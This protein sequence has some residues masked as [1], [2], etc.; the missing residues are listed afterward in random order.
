M[1]PQSHK[2]PDFGNFETLTS[3]S[4]DKMTFGCWSRGQAQSILK[5][6]RWWLSPSPGRGE[7]YE[8]MFARDSSVH[9][10]CSNSTLTNLLFGLCK[11]IWIIDP[12]I[13]RP[14][15]IPE[16]QHTPL[17]PKCCELM[18]MPQLL[19]FLLSS[20]F[21]SQLSPSRNSTS[22]SSSSTIFSFCCACLSLVRVLA[23]L[24]LQHL[25]LLKLLSFS[26][27]SIQECIVHHKVGTPL[28]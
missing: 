2:S 6:G 16:F 10:K 27:F 8:S 12:L 4:R 15:L 13:A 23:S 3:E 19:L 7:S 26:H 28:Y 21:N 17:P 5:G 24:L 14:N 1:G 18:S 25:E 11:S 20:P 9:Q 22:S